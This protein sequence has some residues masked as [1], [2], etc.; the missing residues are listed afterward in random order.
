M[1]NQVEVK[2]LCNEDDANAEVIIART[3]NLHQS[4]LEGSL[5]AIS[6]FDSDQDKPV[7]M[8]AI[9]TAEVAGGK[10]SY[11]PLGT[12]FYP[13]DTAWDQLTPPQC[14]IP[15]EDTGYLDILDEEEDV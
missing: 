14:A 10:A 4:V 9:M 11:A 5:V 7:I 12:L 2:V 3:A 13:D 15:V 6:C 8:L 1:S